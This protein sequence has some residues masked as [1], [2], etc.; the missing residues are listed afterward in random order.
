M[1]WAA[2]MAPGVSAG[3]HRLRR[4]KALTSSARV[5]LRVS[6]WRRS[7]SSSARAKSAVTSSESTRPNRGASDGR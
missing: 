1:K 6:G 4:M 5:R 7:S 2:A 3:S